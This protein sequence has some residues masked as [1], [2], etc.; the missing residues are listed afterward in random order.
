MFVL[1]AKKSNFRFFIILT[2]MSHKQEYSCFVC[3]GSV[4]S[5]NSTGLLDDHFETT[6][7]NYF[8]T[9]EEHGSKFYLYNPNSIINIRKQNVPTY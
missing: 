4:F 2:T 9:I 7:L 6:V 8:I 1:L 3:S 5:G